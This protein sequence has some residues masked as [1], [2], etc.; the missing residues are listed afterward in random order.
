MNQLNELTAALKWRCQKNGSVLCQ[1]R[2]RE[3]IEVSYID[4][5]DPERNLDEDFEGGFESTEG[6]YDR[7]WDLAG[8]SFKNGDYDLIKMIPE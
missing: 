5:K 4:P 6:I 2:N 7:D 3:W 8:V 1:M